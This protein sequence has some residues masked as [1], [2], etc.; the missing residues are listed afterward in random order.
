M[1]DFFKKK[2]EVRAEVALM[3]A[4][5]AG[6]DAGIAM[7]RIAAARDAEMSLDHVA[8]TMQQTL[9]EFLAVK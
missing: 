2:S 3:A 4:F 8:N 5:A 6:L 7:V 1:F 9:D